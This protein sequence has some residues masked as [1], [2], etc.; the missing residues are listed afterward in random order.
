MNAQIAR[1]PDLGPRLS[2]AGLV[3][4]G[5]LLSKYEPLVNL[6]V[7]LQHHPTGGLTGP[8]YFGRVKF[9]ARSE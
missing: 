8:E 9:S 4:T 5:G 2:Q 1:V 3:F 7:F 6:S